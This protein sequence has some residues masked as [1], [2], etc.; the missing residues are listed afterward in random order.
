MDKPITLV[1]ADDHPVFRKGLR[2]VIEP[3]DEFRILGEAENGECALKLIEEFK[4]QVGVIDIEM[5]IMNGFDLMKA[6]HVRHIPMD[7]IFLTM[8]K[9]QD[10]F[11]EAMELGIRGYVLKESA[12]HDIIE[13]IRIVASGKYYISPLLS[14]FLV[15]RDDRLKRLHSKH[16]SITLLTPTEKK[17][18]KLI[19]ENKTS[20]EIANEL[21]VSPKTIENHRDRIAEK[22]NLR[23]HH[24]LLKFAIENKS[25]L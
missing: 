4:P 24:T 19:A 2:D 5:P 16:P 3:H 10:I 7:I 22:L 9:E 14:S 15:C 1:I 13:S 18:L 6:L 11:D 12:V 25:Y 23:G 20:P 8:Y 21:C 17:V